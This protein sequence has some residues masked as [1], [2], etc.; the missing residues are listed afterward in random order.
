MLIP[1]L[2]VADI[3]LPC[4]V[5][6]LYDLAYNLWW[7]WSPRARR[8]FSA[9]DGVAWTHYANPV[10]LLINIDRADEP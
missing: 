8:L 6:K 10:Q 1:C 3:E 5:R 9:I 2:T 4:E 7:T